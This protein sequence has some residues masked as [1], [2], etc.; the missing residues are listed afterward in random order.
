MSL[1]SKE[2]AVLKMRS[3]WDQIINDDRIWICPDCGAK[4]TILSEICSKCGVEHLSQ[5]AVKI[6]RKRR[7]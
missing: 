7:K 1:S 3:I 6:K 5:G 4:T 2:V